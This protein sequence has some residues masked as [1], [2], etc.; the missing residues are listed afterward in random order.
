MNKNLKQIRKLLRKKFLMCYQGWWQWHKVLRHKSVGSA[1]A[2]ILL[3]SANQEYSYFALLHLDEMLASRGLK[4]AVI[5]TYDQAV[6][7]AAH[8]F[9]DYIA[10]TIYFTRQQAEQLM[11]YSCLYEFDRRLVIASLQEPEGRKGETLVGKRGITRE[12]VFAVGV[13]RVY[14]HKV[15]CPVYKGNDSEVKEFLKVGR[16]VDGVAKKN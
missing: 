1:T 15:P 14:P 10:E 3:P 5:L 11:Q 7:K 9:S 12:E 13:Y 6:I 8:L 4:D 2:V 16:K